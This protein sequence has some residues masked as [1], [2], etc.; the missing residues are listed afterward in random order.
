MALHPHQVIQGRRITG[1]RFYGNFI[2]AVDGTL[3]LVR[4][5][6]DTDCIVG[7]KMDVQVNGVS[8][9]ADYASTPTFLDGTDELEDNTVQVSVSKGDRVALKTTSLGSFSRVGGSL[10][11]TVYVEDGLP[12]HYGGTSDTSLLL[13]TGSKVFTTQ[14]L[15]GYVAGSRVRAASLANPTLNYM[16]GVVTSYAGTT[17]TVSMDR[18]AG[19]GTFAD[20]QLTLI[21]DVGGPGPAG[22]DGDPG[23]AG[24]DGADGIFSA[25]ASQAEAEAGTENTKGMTPLRAA[26]AIAALA[27]GAGVPVGGLTGEV[28]TKLSGTDGDA[29]W[30]TPAG[31]TLAGDVD[32]AGSDNTV[33]KVQNRSVK[34]YVAGDWSDDFTAYN[35]ADW[36]LTNLPPGTSVNNTAD[37]LNIDYPAVGYDNAVYRL[38]TAKSYSMSGKFIQIFAKSPIYNNSGGSPIAEWGM[39]VDSNNY[40]RIRTNPYYNQTAAKVVVAG[41]DVAADASL[42]SGLFEN[43]FW[44]IEHDIGTDSFKIS[45]APAGSPGTLTLRATL[46]RGGLSLTGMKM[47][48]TGEW[49]YAT[50][51]TIKYDTITSNLPAAD[52]MPDNAVMI[53]NATTQKFEAVPPASQAEAL[54]GS[55]NLKLVTPLRVAQAIAAKSLGGD[56]DGLIATNTVRKLQSRTLK[57]WAVPVTLGDDF[58]D[59]SFDTAKWG[60]QGENSTQI[61]SGT[62]IALRT[63]GGGYGGNRLLYGKDVFNFDGKSLTWDLPDFPAS[64]TVGPYNYWWAGVVD[65]GVVLAG[66]YGTGEPPS[67][68][69][70]F[71]FCWAYNAFNAKKYFNNG[72]D[73]TNT[74]GTG[75]DIT[76]PSGVITKMRVRNTANVIY[77]DVEYRSGPG[78]W[79]NLGTHTFDVGTSLSDKKLAFQVMDGASAYNYFY[80]NEV[81]T[82]IVS[83]DEIA[84]GSVVYWDGDSQQFDTRLASEVPGGGATGKVLSKV[85][86]ADGDV[87][88]ANGSILESSFIDISLPPP[89]IASGGWSTPNSTVATQKG[90]CIVLESGIASGNDTKALLRALSSVST[91]DFKVGF[92]LAARRPNGSGSPAVGIGFWDSTGGSLGFVGQTYTGGG[93]I[94]HYIKNGFTAGVALGA[95]VAQCDSGSGSDCSGIKYQR[96]TRSGGGNYT[97]YV[98]EDGITW[99]DVYTYGNTTN[100]GSASHIG[101]FIDSLGLQKKA[102]ATIFYW[103]LT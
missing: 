45:T 21:G 103:S 75:V 9:Y 23:P 80:I 62:R 15:L 83:A 17:L 71:R 41:V 49:K 33:R 24:N 84:D 59:S 31:G 102:T 64:F 50:N 6:S 69:I 29:D 92:Y 82:S 19:S 57:N 65:D 44:R 72:S 67:D 4:Y 100:S 76:T 63:G 27:G 52:P 1:S 46:A 98:S 47:W 89:T 60:G 25:I 87:A 55:E 42:G 43:V 37:R 97:F 5:D 53:W 90:D 51:G 3:T 28:L 40:V 94:T 48:I 79:V 101:L 26:Q 61:E 86:G 35:P 36:D 85:S 8:I 81:T 93:N 70:G 34:A 30:E 68:F 78:V 73:S 11:A 13:G 56:V 91:F 2:V 77:Y 18:G 39:F 32:G 16:E 22:P 54:A 66:S 95:T 20:W 96:I 7:M 10:Y 14:K 58:N 12:T 88:W 99:W 74:G 38:K